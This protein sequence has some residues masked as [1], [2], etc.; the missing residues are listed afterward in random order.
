[1]HPALISHIH[2]MHALQPAILAA[3]KATGLCVGTAVKQG[4][5]QVGFATDL[6]NGDSTWTALSAY[7]SLPATLAKLRQIAEDGSLKQ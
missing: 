6:P 1:M 3:K 4:K 7:Q 5:F 2:T